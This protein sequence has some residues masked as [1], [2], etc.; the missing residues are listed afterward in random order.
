MQAIL[1]LKRLRQGGLPSDGTAALSLC[2]CDRKQTKPVLSNK[3]QVLKQKKTKC[4][5]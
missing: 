2:A 1:P 3:A 4:W 5:R